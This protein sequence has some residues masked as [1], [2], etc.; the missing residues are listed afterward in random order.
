MRS[1]EVFA[2]AAPAAG[3]TADIS[4]GRGAGNET[5]D[6]LKGDDWYRFL[7]DCRFTIGV[8]GG[9][10]VLDWDG[11]INAR[12]HAYLAAHPDASFEEVE[13]ACFPGQD[14]NLGLMALSPRHLEACATRTCQVL[15][16][17][18]YNG[19][20]TPGL[21]YIPLSADLSNIS[22]V[23]AQMKSEPERIRM[24]DAAYRDIVDSG[25]WTYRGFVA[26]VLAHASP[27]GVPTLGS[28]AVHLTSRLF[29]DAWRGARAAKGVARQAAVRVL[30]ETRVRD[31]VCMVKRAVGRG[32]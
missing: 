10:S 20:L 27:V 29:D 4:S 32:A 15:V 24:V 14:G 8:E 5:K 12:T 6:T 1:S 2:E 21:H 3:L 13:A 25:D 7:L 16:E 23:L 19:V 9:A 31:F 30:G 18:R 26:K 17:G 22:D 28:A 11:S